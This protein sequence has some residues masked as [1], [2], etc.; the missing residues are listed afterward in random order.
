MKFFSD[1]EANHALWD[2]KKMLEFV[3]G[4]FETSNPKEI[5]LFKKAGYRAEEVVEPEPA[6]PEDEEE[7]FDFDEEEEETAVET[8]KKK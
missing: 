4:E 8:K 3:N 1:L 6:E 2:G 7:D 5:E